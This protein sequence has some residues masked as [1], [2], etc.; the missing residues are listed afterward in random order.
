ICPDQNGRA[1]ARLL[2]LSDSRLQPQVALLEPTPGVLQVAVLRRR[3]PSPSTSSGRQTRKGASAST[4]RDLNAR[5]IFHPEKSNQ[6]EMT[7]GYEFPGRGD[8][9]TLSGGTV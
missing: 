1:I 2:V 7:T 8:S 6:E 9:F 4:R 5:L 3:P